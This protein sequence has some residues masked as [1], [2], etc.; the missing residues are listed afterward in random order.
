MF[1]RTACSAYEE[2]HMMSNGK[3]LRYC[4]FGDVRR[5][6]GWLWQSASFG[7]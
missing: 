4:T 3:L 1:S 7:S 6:G 2:D 5:E